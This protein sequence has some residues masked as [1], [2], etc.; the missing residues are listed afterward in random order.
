[1]T[2]QR[3][4]AR[5]LRKSSAIPPTAGSASVAGSGVSKMY[6]A[7]STPAAPPESLVSESLLWQVFGNTHAAQQKGPR[8]LH[9]QALP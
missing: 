8:P 1:M 4:A 2:K 3:Y 7:P 6:T 9:A 5:D